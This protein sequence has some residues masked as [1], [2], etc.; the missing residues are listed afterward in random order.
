MIKIGFIGVGNMGGALAKAA[1]KNSDVQITVTDIISEKAEKFAE[2]I[3]AESV[4]LENICKNSDYIFIGVKPQVI[5]ELL[6]QMSE[7]L[8]QRFDKYI[9]VSMAAGISINKIEN[10]I[11]FTVPIIRIMPNLPVS[12]NEGMIVYSL[13]KK[14]T[15]EEA[16][17]LTFAMKYSGTWDL[18]EEDL[19]D[20]ASALSGCGPAFVFMYI[21]ALAKAGVECGLPYEK[22]IKYAAQTAI[23]S[24]KMLLNGNA[25]AEDLIT[26]VC[27]PGGS[28]IEG[29]K[30]LRENSLEEKAV[31]AVKKSYKRTIELGKS[32]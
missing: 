13:N 20:A 28:T 4:S 30:F 29:V 6:V 26:A 23:G 16:S 21:N 27:S 3:G 15:A 19:I 32:N 14:V 9:L 31:N 7:F 5:S 17:K 8:K 12:V 22:S 18:I 2:S 24:A 1:A 11:G 25:N 10:C